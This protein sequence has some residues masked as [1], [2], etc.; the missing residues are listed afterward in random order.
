MAG[1]SC[2]ELDRI[3]R[4]CTGFKA[5][6]HQLSAVSSILKNAHCLQSALIQHAPGSGKTETALLLALQSLR[7]GL[8]ERVLYVNYATDLEDQ[9]RARA[10]NFF[11]NLQ[12][13]GH[14]VTHNTRIY[15]IK[16]SSD[17]ATIMRRSG[18]IFS[19][20]QKFSARCVPPADCHGE[21]AS[22]PGRT[23]L[24]I[25]EAHRGIPDDGKWIKNIAQVI[26]GQTLKILLTATP[27]Q[28]TLDL[29]GTRDGPFL[30]PFHTYTIKDAIGSRTTLSA[31][32]HYS[33]AVSKVVVDGTSL[34]D[35]ETCLLSDFLER[36]HERR[37]DDVL[38][39]RW[40]A[41]ILA[42][43]PP[44]WQDMST[45]IEKMHQPKH[46]IVLESMQ[47]VLVMT[48]EL[49]KQIAAGRLQNAFGKTLN[50]GCFFS[51]NVNGVTDNQENGCDDK[52]ALEAA[53]LIVVCQKYTTG[54]DEW[55]LIAVFLCRRIGSPELLMQL[56]GR[57]ARIRPGSGKKM[58]YVVDFMNDPDWV[59]MAASRF[60]L[61]TRK[62]ALGGGELRAVEECIQGIVGTQRHN[63]SVLAQKM[64]MCDQAM[65]RAHIL[66]WFELTAEF[67]IHISLDR[68]NLKCLLRELNLAMKDALWGG[69]ELLAKRAASIAIYEA[70]S[71]GGGGQ[72]RQANATKATSLVTAMR[73]LRRLCTR[74]AP[75]QKHATKRPFVAEESDEESDD[76]RPAKRSRSTATPQQLLS[77]AV[78]RMCNKFEIRMT[79]LILSESM[80]DPRAAVLNDFSFSTFKLRSFN[81][82]EHAAD[83]ESAISRLKQELDMSYKKHVMPWLLNEMDRQFIDFVEAIE[84]VPSSSFSGDKKRYE[85]LSNFATS[86]FRGFCDKLGGQCG[87]DVLA[88]F[89]CKLI[90]HIDGCVESSNNAHVMSLIKSKEDL[91]IGTLVN[92]IMRMRSA[93]NSADECRQTCRATLSRRSRDFANFLQDLSHIEGFGCLSRETIVEVQQVFHWKMID[94]LDAASEM[95]S[96]SSVA[97]FGGA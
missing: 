77:G 34:R 73:P 2:E 27:K 9:S 48:R 43:L 41:E 94:K 7:L 14:E 79:K 85:R 84:V 40:A 93:G 54:W 56:L 1:T 97:E 28:E 51:S 36:L 55:R 19:L 8:F 11:K 52:E 6:E 66:R 89:T 68:G 95:K 20:L 57:G 91:L 87:N 32:D 4:K 47:E 33:S 24:V 64:R 18:L 96:D 69:C 67:G 12:G 44:M 21:D 71:G 75:I 42:S 16:N 45:M 61:E 49:K 80:I 38:R 17:V 59:F 13:G 62:Y 53:D 23:L 30:R 86:K 35:T 72:S 78:D 70:T 50:V 63:L 82:C 81:H 76:E 65:L 15:T 29:Y 83:V 90:A 74:V 10:L 22:P 37:H 25:D 26:K 46:L 5:R 31:L 39:V 60:Y 88:E 3:F 92:D 58:P